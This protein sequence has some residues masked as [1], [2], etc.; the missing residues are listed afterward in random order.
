M[1]GVEGYI[2]SA[3]SGL[4]AGIN[5]AMTALGRDE[6]IFPDET[7]IGAMGNYV[8]TGAVSGDFQPMNANFGIIAPLRER[9]RGGKRA[10]NEEYARRAIEA[11]KKIK[12]EL[13]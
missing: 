2:E 3:A 7:M 1:T 8:A 13:L 6:I 10:R 9:V 12:E 11:V 4:Y 5:A